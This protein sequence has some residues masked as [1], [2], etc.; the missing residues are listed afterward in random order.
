MV[1]LTIQMVSQGLFAQNFDW[2]KAYGGASDESLVSIQADSDGNVVLL[3]EFTSTMDADPSTDSLPLSTTTGWGVFISKLDSDGNLLW[4]KQIGNEDEYVKASALSIDANGNIYISGE[5]HDTVD[6]DP[7]AGVFDLISNSEF[8]PGGAPGPPPEILTDLYIIRL[9]SLG[10]LV[11]AKQIDGASDRNRIYASLISDDGWLYLTGTVRDSISFDSGSLPY[12]IA[13]SS[14]DEGFT[15]KYD[16]NGTLIWSKILHGLVLPPV[17]DYGINPYDIQTDSIGN[18]YLAGEWYGTSDFDPNADTN[19]VTAYGNTDAFVLSLNSS[20]EFIWVKQIGGVNEDLARSVILDE[21][22]QSIIVSGGFRGYTDFDP[23]QGIV[24]LASTIGS[25]PDAFVLN[26]DFDGNYQWVRTFGG[27]GYDLI[28]SSVLD[29]FGNIYVAGTF[30]APLDLDPGADSAI[31]E[32]SLWSDM[33]ISRFDHEGNFIWG[34]KLDYTDISENSTSL[35]ISS[36]GDLFLAGIFENGQT[37]FD[38]GVDTVLLS[39]VGQ[40]DVFVEKMS[41]CVVSPPSIEIQSCGNYVSPSGNHVWESSGT[42]SD[43]I[44]SSGCDSIIT[45]EL[46][47]IDFT[48]TIWLDVNNQTIVC[49]DSAE[50]Y[51]WI[52]CISGLTIGNADSVLQLQNNGSFAVITTLDGCIDTS[53][54][55]TVSGLLAMDGADAV[56]VILYPNPTDGWLGIKG[57]TNEITEIRILDTSGKIVATLFDLSPKEEIELPTKPG[58]YLIDILFRNGEVSHQRI[59]KI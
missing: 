6:F 56:K 38:L 59:V 3:G 10:E 29:S 12:Q 21:D 20:G 44:F 16:L 33:F 51:E 46:T 50:T 30:D 34:D 2:A 14:H 52:E 27:I 45:V 15:V 58:I 41:K 39:H 1:F 26:L 7:G 37:D 57:S 40:N 5:F 23:G 13:D 49:P 17:Y 54:C 22:R 8:L 4:S 35:T 9:S 36:N 28:T 47:I 43:N 24:E 18:I 11:W 53:E 31:I 19:Y 55:I 42:Y 48:P 25:N 32:P